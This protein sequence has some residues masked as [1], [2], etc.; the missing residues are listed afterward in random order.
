MKNNKIK[1][2][3]LTSA[4]FLLAMTAVLFCYA[5][6]LFI[7]DNGEIEIYDKIFRLHVIANSNSKADQDVKLAVRDAL[8]KKMPELLG[9]CRN[10]DEAM[11]RAE[12]CKDA[13]SEIAN[14]ELLRLGKTAD[15]RVMIGYEAYPTKNYGEV[16]LPAGEYRS[17]RVIIGDG[18]GKNWWCVLFPTLCL[19]PAKQKSA[20]VEVKADKDAFIAA[21]FTPE[22]Y[23]L[24]TES[25]TPK[26][27]IKFKIIELVGEFLHPAG[28]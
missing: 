1:K 14:D 23:R 5:P 28:K 8:L 9:D 13:L 6:A 24:I 17:L 18:D 7:F 16:S 19:S 3:I 4:A 25:N 21:G 15:A 12:E 10:A 20:A 2:V 27:K 22:Q 11:K 26:F